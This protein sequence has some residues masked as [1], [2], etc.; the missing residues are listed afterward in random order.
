MRHL[1][2]LAVLVACL[3]GTSPLE[4]VLR[5]RVYRRWRR[6]LVAAL[7]GFI[8]GLAW[9]RYAVHA[10]QWSFD[11]RYLTGLRPGGLPLEEV[12]FFVVVPICAVLTLE[13]VRVCRP[14][15]TFGDEPGAPADTVPDTAADDAPDG[16]GAVSGG[17]PGQP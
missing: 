4:F 17:A 11:S 12:L 6:L 8:A 7:P 16:P 9:D 13:A 5:T 3:I 2:Y 1:T 15:W 10:G 14:G